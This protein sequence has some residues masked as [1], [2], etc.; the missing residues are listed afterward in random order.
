MTATRHDKMIAAAVWL[1]GNGALIGWGAASDGKAV[2]RRW[3]TDLTADPALIVPMLGG[4]KNSV[5]VPTG[6]LVIIDIDKHGWYE[7]LVEVGL[8]PTFAVTS[9]TVRRV[10]TGEPDGDGSAEQVFKGRHL[11]VAAPDQYDVLTVPGVWQGGETRRSE[12]G[13]QSMVLGPWSLRVDGV[14]EV[15][16]GVPR[17]IAEVPAS[18]L[19]FIRDHPAAKPGPR[20]DDRGGD[21]VWDGSMG[22]RHDYLRDRIRFWRGTG[23]TGQPLRDLVVSHI[24]KH[25]IPLARAG[26]EVID[27]AEIERMC[28]GAEKKYGEDEPYHEVVL[29]IAGT[30]GQQGDTGGQQGTAPDPAVD[31]DVYIDP[32]A[33]ETRIDR[34]DP[35]DPS[36]LP[37][38]V[39]LALL[40]DHFRPLTDAPWS[41]LLLA[42]CV[43]MSALVGPSPSLHWRG[44]H[45]AALFGCLVGHSGVGRKGATMREVERAFLQVDPLLDDIQTGG[46]ASGEVL[47]DILN[48]SKTST[49]GTSLI[50]EHEIASVLVIAAREGSILSGNLRKAWDGDR[51]ESRSRAKSKS[52]ATGYTVSFLGGVTPGE[53]AKRLSADAIANGWANRFLWFFSEKRPDGYSAT[54]D[55]TM[56][57]QTVDYLRDCV[58]YGRHLGGS[59]LIRPQFTMSLDASAEARLNDLAVSLDVPPVGTIGALRQRM[60]AHVVRLAMVA[61]L[62]DQSSVVSDDHVAFG[63]AM[64]GYA[65]DSMR[66]VFGLRVDDPLAMLVIEVL[67]QVPDRWLNTSDLRRVTGNK[68]HSRLMSALDILLG[69]GLIVREDRRTGSAK[70]G[71]PSV[72]YRLEKG[73]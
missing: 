51:V 63:E 71:R 45:R 14:Y 38:P 12:A 13:E 6:R 21:W 59:H 18:V 10:D 70:G 25:R 68:D 8:P 73:V 69:A 29:R 55:G 32:L 24:E 4:A 49:I 15:L 52:F 22:S 1:A 42:S 40:L 30:G 11:Y 39:G 61:A 9:P 20:A 28:A 16:G 41:S 31:E 72:G 26:G 27:A 57:R 58:E 56:K 36:A 37:L 66:S 65:V 54:H 2:K 48:E 23:I 7:R 43:T 19:D 47:V 17:V 35:L 5:V 60:P 53:L 67:R 46:I 3:K 50:W 62:F 64:A 34:P 44:R 33:I